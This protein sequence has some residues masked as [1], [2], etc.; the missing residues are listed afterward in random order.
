MRD[1]QP[2]A[3]PADP[4]AAPSPVVRA[5]AAAAT[6]PPALLHLGAGE[7]DA[8]PAYLDSGVAHVALV[9]PAPAAL[10]RLRQR[11]AGMPQVAIHPLAVAAGEG[12]AT[13]RIFNLPALSSLRAPAELAM[14]FPG[15]RQVATAEVDTVTMAGLLTSFLARLA[16]PA[17][18]DAASAPAPVP[19]AAGWLVIDTPGEE[20]TV[21]DGLQQAGARHHFERIFLRCG[22]GTDYAG[23][24]PADALRARIETMGYRQ[25]AADPGPDPDRPWLVFRLDRRGLQIAALEEQLQEATAARAAL[26][27]SLTEQ[28]A[29]LQEVTKKSDWRGGQMQ[30]LKAALE[31]ATQAQAELTAR[32]EALQADLTLALRLQAMAQADL[33]DL[34]QRH[35]ETQ[36]IRE[37]QDALLQALTPRLQEA[38]RH[39]H[40]LR[41][42]APPADS[43]PS[44]PALA[45]A[46][47]DSPTAGARKAAEKS[48]RGR[49]K[50]KAARAS[51]RGATKG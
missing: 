40:S 33:R 2:P 22:T 7:G 15:L 26:E 19:G 13:L 17:A 36:R 41:P 38:A 20:A 25:E 48:A 32:A 42:L 10:R 44:D 8:L 47:P 35:A 11:S 6:P 37:R 29:T 39:L 9:E 49:G 31:T 45:E 30:E 27:A 4:A 23:S 34:Q 43:A 51:G 50:K 14:L 3:P 24:L 18:P 5:L 16:P 28:A 46:D 1:P 12:R 21:L